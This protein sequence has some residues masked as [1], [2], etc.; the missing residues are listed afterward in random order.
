M[1]QVSTQGV[2]VFWTRSFIYN[3]I[4]NRLDSYSI[5]I[6]RVSLLDLLLIN[7]IRSVYSLHIIFHKTPN[8]LILLKVLSQ[9]NIIPK[10]R[11]GLPNQINFRKKSKQPSTPPPPHFRKIILHI[12][13]DRLV[14]HIR[15]RAHIT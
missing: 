14:A 6:F 12:F 3:K 9:Q 4:L 10:G 7:F 11:V 1:C 15:G 8:P 5:T 2:L 13:Y